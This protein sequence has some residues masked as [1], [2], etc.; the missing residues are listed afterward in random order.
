MR[1][2]FPK[3]QEGCVWTPWPSELT[4][5][6]TRMTLFD[7][8]FFVVFG[9][10]L[11]MEGLVM[12]FLTYLVN[13]SSMRYRPEQESPIPIPLR[14]FNTNMNNLLALVVWGVYFH[15]WGDSTMYDNARPGFFTMCWEVFAVLVVYDFFYWGF[16]RVM[17]Y[18]KLMPYCH[19]V[20]HR[21]RSPTADQS[22]YL[23]PLET[24]GGLACLIF[25][26]RLLGPISKFSFLV[27][28]GIHSTVNIIVHSNLQIP[29]GTFWLF[30]F[31]VQKH[32][33]HHFKMVNNYASIF[34]FADL[35]FGTYE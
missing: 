18:P 32:D 27:L 35:L 10:E 9:C 12:G 4:G 6:L 5:I 20:H 19:G 24:V 34:P 8:Y 21:V 7:R 25:A 30:N 29:H 11:L 2:Q 17:H 33:V 1:K 23:H 16:H 28:F 13:Y 3:L 31:W 26:I 22:T 15:Y 14:V